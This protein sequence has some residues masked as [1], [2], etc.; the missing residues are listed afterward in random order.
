MSSRCS[1]AIC[2]LAA[3]EAP[4]TDPDAGPSDAPVD[5]PPPRPDVASDADLPALRCLGLPPPAV[6][7]DPLVQTGRVFDVVDYQIAPLPGATVELRDRA[8]GDAIA[9]ATTDA[10][11]DYAFSIAT[12]GDPVD[13]MFSISALGRLRTDTYPADPLVGGE[14]PLVI[15][16]SEAEIAA[17]YAD[18]GETY[19]PGA[20]TVIA[21][22]VDCDQ[23]AIA[24][25]T[26]AP[27]P[28]PDRLVY[29]DD[30]A[31]QWDPSLGSSRNGFAL[32]AGAPAATAIVATSGSASFP[33]A[34]IPAATGALTLAVI[35]P[36]E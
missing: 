8:T 2:L 20:R 31:Q 28:T 27:T 13:A 22:V 3:C 21:I 11:G 12:G 36:T 19:A 17:W 23:E 18:A 32:L 35:S 5:A 29:Y 7:D 26:V 1:I 10:A 24:G 15:V 25:S 33:A 14:N 9:A 4:S 34:T 30:V 16:A 6:A